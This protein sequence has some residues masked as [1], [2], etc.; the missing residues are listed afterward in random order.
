MDTE[1][2]VKPT[3]DLVHM[4]VCNGCG[5]DINLPRSYVDTDILTAPYTRLGAPYT[6]GYHINKPVKGV[7]GEASKI[8]EEL[9]ELMDALDQDAKL[10]ALQELSDMYGAMSAFLKK[11]YSGFTM[12]DLEKMSDITKRAFENGE[13]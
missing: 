1:Y 3:E 7:Y 6:P 5:Q 11:H 4:G 2:K 13:R 10:M 9:E 12:K 8:K